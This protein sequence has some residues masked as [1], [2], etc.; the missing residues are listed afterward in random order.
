M[1][2]YIGEHIV[3]MKVVVHDSGLG[4]CYDVVFKSPIGEELWEDCD[5]DEEF[6][7]NLVDKE[8]RLKSKLKEIATLE[9]RLSALK[10][11]VGDV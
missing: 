9:E 8:Y 10:A 5:V 4:G 7:A 1:S 6:V 2:G 11:E 3:E